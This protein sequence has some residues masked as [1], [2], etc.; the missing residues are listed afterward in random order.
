MRTGTLRD[1]DFLGQRTYKLADGSTVSSQTFRIRVLKV[2]DRQI[3]NVRGSVA[4]V[5][6]SLLLGQS[7]LSRF[8]SWSIDNQRR[9]LMLD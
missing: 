4:G 8:R 5:D 1:A 3:E 7:F 2:G 6:G 9:V